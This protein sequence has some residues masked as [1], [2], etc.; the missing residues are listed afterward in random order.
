MSNETTVTCDCGDAALI[1]QGDPIMV[2]ECLCDSCREAGKI[3]EALPGAAP[4]L[5]GKGAT[6]A[7]MYRKDRIRCARGDASM[8]A[9]RLKPESKTRRVLAK[10]CNTP[11]LMEFTSG[12]WI[13][14]YT[15]RWPEELRPSPEMRTMVRDLPADTGMPNDIPNLK[16][17]SGKFFARL[18]GAWIAMRFRR[19]KIDFVTEG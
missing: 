13:D 2:V 3:M 16:G 17:H 5:D 1:L 9:F 12:H 18:L 14:V 19:P 7:A 15:A 4:L 10:C 6:A 11:M 8:E